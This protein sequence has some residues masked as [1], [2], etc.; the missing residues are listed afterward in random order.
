MSS[1]DDNFGDD[2][3]GIKN[4][5]QHAKEQAA[6]LKAAQERLD[7]FEKKERETTVK[8]VLKAKGLPEKVAKFYDGDASEDAVDQWLKENGDV[9]GVAPAAGNDGAATD[10]NALAA[11]R[12][13]AASGST[14]TAEDPALGAGRRV[15]GDPLA[16]MRAIKELPYEELVRQGLMPDP[17]TDP[18]RRPAK[19]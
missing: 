9:F 18:M 7:A 12:L 15:L 6:A 11:A 10:P 17:K 4:L 3:E 5:R 2:S 19:D 14:R 16:L 13:A 8:E 1:D